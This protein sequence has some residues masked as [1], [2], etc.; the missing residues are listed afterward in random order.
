MSSLYTYY[1]L[2]D[3]HQI[4]QDLFSLF[5][6][7][8]RISCLFAYVF[9]IN[10]QFVPEAWTI[11]MSFFEEDVIKFGFINVRVLIMFRLILATINFTCYFVYICII[12][13]FVYILCIMLSWSLKLEQLTYLLF[14]NFVFIKVVVLIILFRLITVTIGFVCFFVYICFICLFSYYLL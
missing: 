12:Y 8:I 7:F 11:N 3:L 2:Q 14:L 10:V 1:Y 4:I 13:L 5:V 9:L 6:F